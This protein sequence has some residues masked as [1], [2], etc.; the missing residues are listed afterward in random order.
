MIEERGKIVNDRSSCMIEI[1]ETGTI[2]V[3]QLVSISLKESTFVSTNVGSEEV[4][5]QSKVLVSQRHFGNIDQTEA[6][7]IAFKDSRADGTVGQNSD[8]KFARIFLE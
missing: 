5:F 7:L 6:S 8:L 1:V 3:D 4:I 2:R